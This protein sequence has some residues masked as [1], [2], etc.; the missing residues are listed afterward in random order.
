MCVYFQASGWCAP[1]SR[2]G[3]NV[4]R[5]L[6]KREMRQTRIEAAECVSMSASAMVVHGATSLLARHSDIFGQEA[7]VE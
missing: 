7:A 5:H 6:R 2:A 4:H 3:T 1:S